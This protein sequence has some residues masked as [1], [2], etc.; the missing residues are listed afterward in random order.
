MPLEKSLAILRDEAERGRLDKDL[1]D[2]FI[3]REVYKKSVSV[4]M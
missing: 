2:V 1:V 3:R 4:E